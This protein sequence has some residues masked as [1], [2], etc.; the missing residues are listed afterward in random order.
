MRGGLVLLVTAT[1]AAAQGGVAHRHGVVSLSLA[2]DAAVVTLQMEAPLESIV[3]FERAPRNDAE[4]RLVSATVD[5]LRGD[6]TLVR[7]DAAAQCMLQEAQVVA[8]A[9]GD[10]H[11][12]GAKQ[13][14]H[15]D[16]K[17]T[18]TFRCAQPSQLRSLDLTGLLA[19]YK[20][21]ARVE[22]QVAGG[23]GQSRQVLSRPN[24]VL[25]W[26]R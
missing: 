6:T 12:K 16:L 11:A 9:L 5:R 18:Y 19:A 25:R 13:D 4:R 3:G 21:I 22:L 24:T 20:R 8:A 15:A 23:S 17:A 10:D 14:E 26:G 1:A 7:L 2:V